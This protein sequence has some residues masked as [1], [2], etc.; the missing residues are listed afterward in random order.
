MN[1]TRRGVALLMA[2]VALALASIYIAEQ[3]RL[4]MLTRRHQR[5]HAEQVQR[6]LLVV[7]A[8]ERAALLQSRQADFSGETWSV[9]G[10][11][12]NGVEQ[13]QIVSQ[14]AADS[15]TWECTVTHEE[16]PAP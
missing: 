15:P 10:T 6:H 12:S 9:Q 2:L 5:L 3:T 13:W 1:R 11:G 7:A 14:R 8:R 4:L 16:E